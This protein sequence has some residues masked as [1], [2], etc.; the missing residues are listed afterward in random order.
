[1]ENDWFSE[2][3]EI[4]PSNIMKYKPNR[5][6]RPAALAAV[7]GLCLGQ[8]A[9]AATYYWDTNDSTAGFGSASGT[10]GT[11]AF[12]ST[13]L[14]GTT[15]TANTTIN[16]ADNV[17]FGTASNP[18]V[19]G[20][21]LFGPTTAQGFLN[22]TFGNPTGAGNGI[23]LTGGTLN[24]ASTSTITTNFNANIIST[25]LQGSGSN[26]I[27]T[28][29]GSLRLQG[30]SANT[31]TGQ[32][33]V[34]AGTLFLDKTAGVNAI[35][36]NVLVQNSS[37]LI[38][39][40]DN[41]I[42]DTATVTVN[43]V[44][45]RWELTGRTETI[46]T[47]NLSGTYQN[48]FGFLT[49]GAGKLTVN[50]LNVSGGGVTLNSSGIGNQSTITA[51]TVTNTGGTWVFGTFNGT[52]SLVVGAGG[53]TIGGGSTM[54]VNATGGS[55]NFISLGGNVT[56]QANAN[57]N[58]ISGLGTLRLNATRTFDV[59]DGAAASDLTIATIVANGTGTGEINKTG[60]GTMTLTGINTFTGATTLGG[61]T[62]LVSGT[63]NSSSG[64]TVNAGTFNYT[65]NTTGLNRA[66]TVAGGNF[67]YNS[68]QVYSGALTFTSGT[69]SGTG[70]LSNTAVTVGAGQIMTPG[71]STG[72]QSVGATTWA[73]AGT[74]QFELN[75]ATGTAGSLING[76]DLLNPTSLAIT[77][78]VGQFN[79]QLIT[80]NSL[81]AAGLAQNFVDANNYSWLFVDAGATITAFNANQF[82]FNT[83]SFQNSF[84]GTFSVSQ[85]TGSDDDKLYL[86]YT[87]IP[88]PSTYAMLG[89]GLG[90]LVWLRR[91]NKK[92]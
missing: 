36:G 60:A 83:S 25:V 75:D 20:N 73:N 77:A 87:A 9:H 56:S 65:N 32:T 37:T 44:N 48:N 84:T 10:W 15:S 34:N 68:S 14:T 80:L 22:M 58:T 69:I 2:K 3:S 41:Q 38:S 4:P 17:N 62:L 19:V 43:N 45:A 30:S 27:K 72:S 82:A 42:A 67:R 23:G 35:A 47:L 61:G 5:L 55:A 64:V 86:N 13:D 52:Q 21:N 11:D 40:A 63:I 1:M 53:L 85:G 71:N 89:L 79:L 50:N 33:T 54:A 78:G 76:W 88:E 59:A 7:I 81:Q 6:L 70:N 90:L 39:S 16:T 29:L 74:F 24:L 18:L 91:K 57:A 28:G 26:L 66:V 8:A 12:W 49:G 92:A 51:N 31:Y 46:N